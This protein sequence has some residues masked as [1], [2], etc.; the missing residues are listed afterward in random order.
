MFV[1]CNER[2]KDKNKHTSITNV[3][4]VKYLEEDSDVFVIQVAQIF[5]EAQKFFPFASNCT[6]RG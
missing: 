2:R 4:V 3:V 1:S 6:E 5:V